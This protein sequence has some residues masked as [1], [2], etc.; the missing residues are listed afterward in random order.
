MGGRSRQEQNLKK[1]GL[2]G[3]Y[4]RLPV[5]P[6]GRASGTWQIDFGFR[7]FSSREAVSTSLENAIGGAESGS[8]FHAHNMTTNAWSM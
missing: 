7:A 3:R 4:R 2:A 5:F 8:T 6:V 1:P